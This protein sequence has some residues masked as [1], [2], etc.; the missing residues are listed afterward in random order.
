MKRP[1]LLA[2]NISGEKAETIGM[3]CSKLDIELR[4]VKTDEQ[5]QTI[6]ALCRTEALSE[7][8]FEGEEF[9]DEMLVLCNL[10][11]EQQA[12]LLTDLRSVSGANV[13]LKAVLTEYNIGWSAARLAAELSA[14]RDAIARNRSERH[15]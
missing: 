12:G 10:S 2:F 9:T 14:E 13:S 1:V 8:S 15:P 5:H 3:F 7:A 6:G 11:A 4:D